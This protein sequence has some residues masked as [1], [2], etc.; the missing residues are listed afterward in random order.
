MEDLEHYLVEIVEPTVEDFRREPSSVRRGFLACVVI[1]HAVDYLAYPGDPEQWDSDQH[2][3][4]RSNL[5]GQFR[6]ENLDFGLASEAANAFKHVRATIGTKSE[7]AAAYERPPAIGGRMMCGLSLAGDATGAVIF[8]G[9]N[10]LQ[11]V[12]GAL[13]FLRSKTSPRS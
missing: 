11:V 1:E 7:A 4:K 13:A 5:R 3:G 2:R 6:K 9:H 12:E 10:L 8:N